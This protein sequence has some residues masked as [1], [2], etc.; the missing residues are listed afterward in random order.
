MPLQNH[1]QNHRAL[2]AFL[3]LLLAL[4]PTLQSDAQ[5]VPRSLH[6]PRIDVTAQLDADGRLHVVERQ[7]ILYS[8]NWNG[9]ER[10]FDL[11]P[12]QDLTDLRLRRLAQ[13]PEGGP[14]RV[15]E[16]EEVNRIPGEID[17]WTVV[18]D[19]TVRWRSRLPTDPPF[20]DTLRVY[21]LDYTLSGVLRRTSTGDYRLHH[22]FGF[23]DRDGTIDTLAV[24]L[25]L[26]AA[27]RVVEEDGTPSGAS[28]DGT[29]LTWSWRDLPPGRSPRVTL[30]LE[31]LPE[32]RPAAA[33]HPLPAGLRTAPFLAALA[34]M[35]VMVL[36]FVGRVR[37][38]AR[39]RTLPDVGVSPRA[40][41]PSR[42]WLAKHVFSRPPE[43][44]GALW[45]RGVGSPE[46]T[47]VLA[48]LVEE[49]KL[50]S[51]M[52]APDGDL[53]DSPGATPVLH[54]ELLVPP[55]GLAAMER[56]LLQGLLLHQQGDT[57]STT[58]VKKHYEKRGF[59][60]ASLIAPYLQD[61][62]PKVRPARS[63]HPTWRPGFQ[64][65]RLSY[66]VYT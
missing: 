19:S 29:D 38:S 17:Q 21:E 48:R 55:A 2:L 30:E 33:L 10:R 6:W 22:Q 52:E 12:G 28:A 44:V 36:A 5:Y 61:A 18:N 50:A 42:A 25:S 39:F 57:T 3:T 35:V 37:R 13:D 14:P 27:W 51:R 54:L 9:G 66:T 32:G 64:G 59:R 53:A 43:E 31:H 20:R 47:A 34:V 1:L 62:L 4:T 15:V 40:L 23:G 26:D 60:P 65:S 7:T 46:V 63:L 58:A 24:T 16:M 45:D 11:D 49:G 41:P 56:D 8:G